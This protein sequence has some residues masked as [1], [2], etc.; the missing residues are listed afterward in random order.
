M[1]RKKAELQFVVCVRNEDCEDLELRKIYQVLPDEAAAE[2]DYIRVVDES[3]EDYLYPTDY[4]LPIELSKD[5]EKALAA[6]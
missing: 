6:A 1:K 5:L 4:F 3:G 2:D